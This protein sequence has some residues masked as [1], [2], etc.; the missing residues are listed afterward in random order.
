MRVGSCSGI[1][2]SIGRPGGCY[3]SGRAQVVSAGLTISG[4]LEGI[5]RLV[6]RGSLSA[7]GQGSDLRFQ[8]KHLTVDRALFLLSFGA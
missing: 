2:P 3:Q 7:I 5:T 6:P 8:L 4:Q 1:V